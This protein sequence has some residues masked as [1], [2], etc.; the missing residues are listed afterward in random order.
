MRCS[1]WREVSDSSPHQ[2]P[3]KSSILIKP[4]QFLHLGWV[5]IDKLSSIN[6]DVTNWWYHYYSKGED[7]QVSR[8]C[9]NHFSLS[10]KKFTPD[11]T[12]LVYDYGICH[13]QIGASVSARKSIILMKTTVG[14]S[15]P[16][17]ENIPRSPYIVGYFRVAR[18]DRAHEIIHID[19][20]DS[21]LLLGNPIKLD[22]DLAKR[23]FVEKTKGYWDRPELFV[24]RVGST[25]RNRMARPHE[26]KIIMEE[27]FSRYKNG[28]Q[29][30]F[31][32]TI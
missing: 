25:L 7:A 28:A 3:F 15:N 30:Y 32:K 20:S 21:L 16:K 12:S 23:L 4:V 26:V 29:N 1:I 9:P 5:T 11:F 8:L 13:P 24:R 10:D 31:G 19:P 14:G 18:I 2:S 17:G 27:L 6:S 22:S